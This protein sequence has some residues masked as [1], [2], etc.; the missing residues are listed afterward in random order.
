MKLLKENKIS[1]KQYMLG[2]KEKYHQMIAQ[3]QKMKEEFLIQEYISKH[4]NMEKTTK[5]EVVEDK[6]P[7]RKKIR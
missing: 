6:A 5:I 3:K 2:D 4:I 1:Y 7:T